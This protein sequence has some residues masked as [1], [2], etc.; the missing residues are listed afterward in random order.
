MWT[1]DYAD[2]TAASPNGLGEAFAA[3]NASPLRLSDVTYPCEV[4]PGGDSRSRLTSDGQVN[5]EEDVADFLRPTGI[6]ARIW[7]QSSA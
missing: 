1:R 7:P 5:L 4:P 2:E 3:A 6:A